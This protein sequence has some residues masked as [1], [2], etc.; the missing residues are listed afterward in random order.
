MTSKLNRVKQRMRDWQY[1]HR[2]LRAHVKA[3]KKLWLAYQGG[4][5]D[6]DDFA[7]LVGTEFQFELP[8]PKAVTKIDFRQVRGILK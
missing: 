4:D 3:V 2:K 5:F 8:P 6:G 7:N 1:E